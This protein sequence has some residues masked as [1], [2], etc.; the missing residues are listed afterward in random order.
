MLTLG[1]YGRTLR[2]LFK[3]AKH[4]TQE[5][6]GQFA[7]H[8]NCKL[9]RGLVEGQSKIVTVTGALSL[10]GNRDLMSLSGRT[11]T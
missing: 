3:L 6:K 5:T 11:Y 4:E 8:L 2:S 7:V 1:F 10:S 9:C